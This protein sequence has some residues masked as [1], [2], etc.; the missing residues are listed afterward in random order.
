MRE[1]GKSRGIIV[2]P[3]RV[4][5]LAALLAACGSEDTSGGQ[6]GADTD[7]G[8]VPEVVGFE[9]SNDGWSG[10][11]DSVSW[12]TDGGV[13]TEL[14]A[15]CAD[16][17]GALWCPCES[18]AAC[19]SGFCIPSRGGDRVCTI[20][21]EQDCPGGLACRLVRLPGSDPTYACVDM[22]VSLCRPCRTNL[23]CQGFFGDV[24]N[25]CVFR[26]PDVGSFCGIG[27]E[28]DETCPEG[29]T[30]QDGLELEGRT[31]T[32]QCLPAEGPCDCSGRAVVEA[33]STVCARQTCGGSRICTAD[34]LTQCDARLPEPEICDGFDNN[35]NGAFD[36][37]SPDL[38]GD[39]LA[40]CV[41]DDR[42]GDAIPNVGDNCPDDANP[43]QRD[44]DED[45][46]GDVCDVPPVP[47]LTA[48]S[49]VSPSS[50]NAPRVTGQALAGTRVTLHA[51][52]GCDRPIGTAFASAAGSF[53]AQIAVASDALT[54]VHATATD[55]TN[56]ISSE[57]SPE[58]LAYLEDSSAPPPPELIASEP[59]PPS[60]ERDF[61][62][63]GTT[64]PLALVTLWTDAA[65]SVP[66]GD[67][68]TAEPDGSFELYATAPAN[69]TM[70]LH[71][72]AVDQAGN[73]SGCSHPFQYRHD[74]QPPAPPTM[75]GTFPPSPSSTVTTLT[76]IGQT[77]PGAT[78]RV[79][80]R[81]DCAGEPVATQ[82]AGASQLF[83]A[84]VTVP[85][86][87]VTVFTATAM[88][89]AGNVSAC[90]PTSLT[91]VHDNEDPP[92]PTLL[93]TRPTSPGRS[94]LPA[95]VGRSEP[96]AKVELFSAPNCTGVIYGFAT[97][98]LDGAWE[99]P[100]ASVLP[101]VEATFYARA[102]DAAGRRSACTPEPLRYLH[103]G[104]PPLAP[105]LETVTPAGPSPTPT[106]VVAGLAEPL[107]AV[108]L[109]ADPACEGGAIAATTADAEGTFAIAAPATPNTTSTWWAVATDP[110]GNT[111]PCSATSVSY[112]HD[113]IAPP[114]PTVS[115]S[116]PVSP[117][118]NANP[119]IEGEAEPRA[120]VEV[121]LTADC[122]GLP[123]GT[124]AAADVGGAF[125][126][127]IAIAPNAVNIVR[128][129]ATDAAGNR[130][131]CSASSLS[132]RHDDTEPGGPVFTG[133]TPPSPS[134]TSTAPK[135][136]GRAEAG[137]TVRIHGDIDCATAP[138]ATGVVTGA[139]TFEVGVTVNANSGRT[140]FASAINDVGLVSPC[141]SPGFRYVHD[142]VA[143]AVPR[144]N[145]AVPASPSN[146]TTTP[147]VR[148]VAEVSATVRIYSNATCTTQLAETQAAA[149]GGAFAATVPA[150][151]N[152]QTAF[153]A[154]AFDAA[155]NASVCSAALTWLH[156]DR[157]PAV[158]VLS[159][160][161]PVS[162]A[163]KPNPTINGSAEVSSTVTFYKTADCT[164]T[165][166]GSGRASAAGAVAIAVT[167]PLDTT[168][169]VRATATDAA[170]NVSGCS[171]AVTYLND[172]T[173]PPPASWVSVTPA[174]PNRT[175]MTPRLDG[176]TAPDTRVQI[177]AAN[178]CTRAAPSGVTTSDANG[179]FSFQTTITAN[180][181][182]SFY[183]ATIDEVGNLSACSA[184]IVYAH[185]TVAPVRPTISGATPTSPA[186][187]R[188]PTIRG[189]AENNATVRLFTNSTCSGEPVGTA[190]ASPNGSWELPGMPAAANTT[191]TFYAAATDAVGNTGMCSTG[192]AYRHDD[193]APRAPVVT[194]TAPSGISNNRT[195]SV[196]GTVDETGLKVRVFKTA[197]C[198]G[199]ALREVLN[200]PL[201]W[202][203]A[204]VQAD[205]NAETA[206]YA[207]AT[208]TAGN[209]S[210]CS[211][212]PVLYRHDDIA[213]LAA[214][215]LATNPDKWSNTNSAP[216]VTGLAEAGSNV[217]IY[218]TGTCSGGA[219]QTTGRAD[220]TFEARVEVGP[221]N[222]QA[223][224]SA[225]VVDPAGNLSAC[226]VPVTYRY[227]TVK[228]TFAGAKTLALAEGA[229]GETTATL[230]WVAASD[231]FTPGTN[232]VYRVCRS[233]LCGATDCD[234]AAANPNNIRTLTPA[235]L[236]LTDSDLQPNTRYYY[237]VHARDEVGNEDTNVVTLSVRTRGRNAAEGIQIGEN[238]SVAD[239]SNGNLH[240]W[241]APLADLTGLRPVSMSLGSSHSCLVLGA[242]D[243][244]CA[245]AN[246]YGQ[247]GDGTTS[248]RTEWTP[249]G[250]LG[251]AARQVAVGLE[252]TCALLTNGEVR[253]W[254]NDSR[255]QL[256][257]G[258]WSSDSQ[259]L[260]AA[261]YIDDAGTTPLTGVRAIAIGD[262]HGCALRSDGSVW[263]WGANGSGQLAPAV[264]TAQSDSA[265]V[266]VA[267]GYVALT[268]GLEHTCGIDGAGA[269]R[270]WGYNVQGQLGD[271]T[272]LNSS[273]PRDT[274]LRQAV[275]IGGS[276]RHTCAA[277]LDGTARCWG[278]NT[279]GELG[280]GAI[281]S[282]RNV[283]VTVSGLSGASH[284][285]GGDKYT[286][287]RTWSGRVSCWGL[288]AGGRLGQG[289]TADSLSP[290]AVALPTAIAG[291]IEVRG[292]AGHTCA[293]SSDG[294][295][296]CW[297]D[298]AAGQLGHGTV[299]P[300]GAELAV[301]GNF[302]GPVRAVAPGGGHTC[303]IGEAGAVRCWGR[304][305]AGQLGVTAG[306]PQLTAVAPGG[307]LTAI[308]LSLG[309]ASTC[310]IR[311]DR[312]VMCWGDNTGGRLGVGDGAAA[313]P[314]VV[315]GLSAIMGMAAGHTH[316]CAVDTFGRVFCWGLN[317]RGQVDG[318][319]SGATVTTAVEVP[320]VAGA[321][322][323][324]AGASHSCALQVGGSVI[325][326]GDN[327]WRQLGR[328]AIDATI[329]APVPALTDA[330]SLAAG[331]AQTCIRRVGG[332]LACWGLN[333]H[334][335][336]GV[337]G[338]TD[339]AS[340]PTQQ[341]VGGVLGPW[342]DLT[343]GEDL[344]CAVT[345]DGGVGC[346]GWNGKRQLGD[347]TTTDRATPVAVR[348]LP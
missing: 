251:G 304:N 151:P 134:N 232:L 23:D 39:G 211:L 146:A 106:P 294:S 40:D 122:G 35:C 234:W 4:A 295:A 24:T 10:G 162:P 203:A 64:E 119:T 42:D 273:V 172:S 205:R 289:S 173:P 86:N 313:I 236:T 91:W 69:G 29:Y 100:E 85:P 11:R 335:A 33:A 297:G 58:G 9:V 269:V 244:R 184:P 181:T 178:A 139:G 126:G 272:Y 43:D 54:F 117:S 190:T 204:T 59:A 266:S 287:V 137:A 332:T 20:T 21:C 141:S 242:G 36:E 168:T 306:Q 45:N 81:P 270:C 19:N 344:G 302:A 51:G 57:C 147:E 31:P 161:N 265:R 215:G 22:L 208:D 318:S 334:G 105:I 121:F 299:S 142:T 97:A 123:V 75:S 224:L 101:N 216:I 340:Y 99:L 61:T 74:D 13:P 53:E 160:T 298:N 103:D 227:D 288:G 260:P 28:T 222:V 331:S 248:S 322:A 158:P 80:G 60:P 284:I 174:S 188:S 323:V 316:Q 198:S 25:R 197:D 305:E 209:V 127:V 324:T 7:A 275:A 339:G 180:T 5:L 38:D 308:G 179:G 154:K 108:T 47:V 207:D 144:W 187:S 116:R 96:H 120:R 327:T 321:V 292:E 143:P 48:I 257:N 124:F 282:S 252:H 319:P 254:G 291:V 229:G 153:Y 241:G 214:L 348:C 46:A 115:R 315:T 125:S 50:D 300:S 213:P 314:R 165:A 346:W 164:G 3:G 102:T 200:A 87:S 194:A 83:I 196:S 193:I 163:N 111:S 66:A 210:G 18:N 44:R 177:Y 67:A 140:F 202:T 199:A 243:V 16:D 201:T 274:G 98:G 73:V 17:P 296:A 76:V 118:S 72:S 255:G 218:L 155:G 169:S 195:P 235:T 95:V 212:M 245:G 92:P 68:V 88:D 307:G 150:T 110:S 176:L 226:S 93:A 285:D 225:R 271:G 79:H 253:C 338:L 171:N 217:S 37:G 326:W 159:S 34:G 337:E 192:L 341:A 290:V 347:G 206:F 280:D 303:V 14:P 15:W 336:L 186:P 41:D 261:V 281:A 191:T 65:C 249:I 185:D 237:M 109:H 333:L 130:S 239:L 77:E 264:A 6:V 166:L 8:G 82:V 277:L 70:T 311:P 238:S 223:S 256:G 52:S 328:S 268:A 293:R 149:V 167:L 240:A 258:N 132:Y 343:R 189:A 286:C 170:G 233:T 259:S 114:A 220:G 320:G 228:P 157:A 329:A 312:T 342:S 283:P 152:A 12:S 136:L 247:L 56:G 317:N 89:A 345:V 129:T 219:I 63:A 135:L 309:T 26:G 330:A 71:A 156:D 138:I 182:T 246:A 221:A 112:L 107:A 78:V 231:N 276:R 183:A 104:T 279:A 90:S 230:A 133:S 27:C 49:P 62:L 84:I 325:C 262:F 267:Q 250:G 128:A 148:G 263:C 113:A 30:C 301:L 278:V 94:L 131:A 55:T 145:G 2:G 1:D 310:A 175:S 32:R